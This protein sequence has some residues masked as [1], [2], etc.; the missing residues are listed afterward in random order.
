M[1]AHPQPLP[2]EGSATHTTKIAQYKTAD[3]GTY[4]KL[5][6]FAYEN[7]RNPTEA[8]HILWGYLKGMQQG[9]R[10]RRQHIIGQFIADLSC[11]RLKLIIEIDGG[12]HQLP[13]QQ[14]SDRQRTAWLEAQGYTVMRFTNEEIIADTKHVLNEIQKEIERLKT[15]E[16]GRT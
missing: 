7:R 11:P 5:K 14:A 13:S 2:R 4:G 3:S 9:V 15:I 6:E 16:Y 8:E 1:E 10:F 12:Y